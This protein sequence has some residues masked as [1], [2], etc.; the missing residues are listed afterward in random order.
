[1]EKKTETLTVTIDYKATNK[2]GFKIAGDKDQW[3]TANKEILDDLAKVEKGDTVE[4]TFVKNGVFRNVSK[5]E[6]IKLEP[7]SETKDEPK[8]GFTCEDCGKELKDGKYKKCFMC[9]KKAPAKTQVFDEPEKESKKEWVP[10]N[11]NNP[12]K[13]AQIQRGNALNAAAAVVANSNIEMKD[14]SPEALAEA[15]KIIAD[16]F[17]DWLRAE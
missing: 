1:M 9:N 10:G 6:K 5:I 15:T 8:S 16:L 14:K 17:L 4:I 7:K 11:Y 2:K 12:E 3:Y 13:T